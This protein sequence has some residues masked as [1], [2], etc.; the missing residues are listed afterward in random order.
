MFSAQII[1]DPESAVAK[2]LSQAIQKLDALMRC[3]NAAKQ[4]GH[5]IS[6]SAKDLEEVYHHDFIRYLANPAGYTQDGNTNQQIED[7]I[8]KTI[9]QEGKAFIPKD[10]KQRY[11][12]VQKGC[13]YDIL[14]ENLPLEDSSDDEKNPN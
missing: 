4:W 2:T 1:H 5:N 14:V 12:S 3:G 9:P 6:H 8:T 13:N 10:L 7:M 11:T